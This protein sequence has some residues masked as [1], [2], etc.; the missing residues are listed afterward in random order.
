MNSRQIDL[1]EISKIAFE[2]YHGQKQKYTLEQLNN[3][4]DTCS[5]NIKNQIS[6]HI[7]NL[8]NKHIIVD[9]LFDILSI[10]YIQNV[11]LNNIFKVEIKNEK[12]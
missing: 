4:D 11:N 2:I 3:I 9:L 7:D 5:F 8:Y 1:N 10:C 6:E 12:I